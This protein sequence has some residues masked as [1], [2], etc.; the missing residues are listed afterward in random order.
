LHHSLLERE[1][2]LLEE[3]IVEQVLHKNAVLVTCL[4]RQL[5]AKAP[6]KS[7]YESLDV[8]VD[9]LGLNNVKESLLLVGSLFFLHQLVAFTFI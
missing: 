1:I 5:S 7:H 6:D 2:T 8:V 3:I 9:Q 4:S